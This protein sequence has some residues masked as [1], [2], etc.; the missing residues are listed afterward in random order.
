VFKKILVP[1]DGS[2]LGEA[3]LPHVENLA[4]I[5][6]SEVIMY[7]AVPP[8]DGIVL[9]PDGEMLST[10]PEGRAKGYASELGDAAQRY[11]DGLKDKLASKGVTVRTEVQLGHPAESIIDFAKTG[12]IDLIAMSTH[13]RSGISRW[14]FGSVADK[15]LHAAETPVLLIRAS[16]GKNE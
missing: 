4:I 3:A 6:N 9:S 12:E 14:V 7:Q 10:V 2:K 16:G 5:A 11:L 1:L 13:G 8:A 15:V